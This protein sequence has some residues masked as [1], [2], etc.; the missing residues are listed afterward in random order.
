MRM[1]HT[2]YL[3]YLGSTSDPLSVKTSRGVAMFR[4]DDCVGE[5]VHGEGGLT[6]GLSR[7]SFAEAVAAGAKTLVL[8]VASAGGSLSEELVNDALAALD[9]GLDIASGLH[10]R[11]RDVPELV[12]AAKRNDR[13]LI[14][15]RDPT[16]NFKV[17]NGSPRKGNRLLTVGTDCSV[18]KMVTTLCIE[19]AMKARGYRADFRATGQTGIL[20]A[21]SGVPLDAVIADFISGAIEQLSPERHDGGWDLIEGQGSLFHPSFAGVSTG[22]LHGAQPDAIV[23]C[24]DP[25]R[26]HMRGLPHFKVPSL[27]QTIAANLEVARLTNADVIAVGIA[28]NTSALSEKDGRDLCT[29]IADATGLPCTDP[30]AHGADPIID[31][32]DECFGNSRPS[33]LR[34]A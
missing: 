2:P 7:M 4:P 21:G 6:L 30:Y 17:G 23:I 8:G 25:M 20:I 3:L 22:L 29:R 5:F 18:G 31:R 19:A 9:A 14:D 16:S 13:R 24:H 27:E 32:I 10:N 28:L 34:S 12:K 26:E 15:V 33:T 11:L 1:I